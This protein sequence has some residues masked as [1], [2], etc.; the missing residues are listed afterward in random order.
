MKYKNKIKFMVKKSKIFYIFIFFSLIFIQ[1]C[2]NKQNE[3]NKFSPKASF[4]YIVS[5]EPQATVVGLDILKKGGSAADAVVASFFMLSV[6]YPV[7]AGLGSGGICIV[8]NSK[9]RTSE[10]IDFRNLPISTG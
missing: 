9:T 4:G 6:T 5:E 7:A 3:I 2:A 1:S 10:S 8:H